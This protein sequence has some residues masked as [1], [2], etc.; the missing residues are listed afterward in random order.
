MRIGVHPGARPRGR[1]QHGVRRRQA[2]VDT[3]WLGDGL[4][5]VPQSP[6]WAGGLE[7]SLS[8]PGWLAARRYE[9]GWGPQYC[10]CA[11]SSG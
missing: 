3:L 6:Q 7:P 2:G 4:L 9:L 10:P 1:S 8:W 5:T 11:T